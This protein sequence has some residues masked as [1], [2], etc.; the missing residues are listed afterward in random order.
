L[1]YTD[2][3]KCRKKVYPALE[4]CQV[5]SKALHPRFVAMPVKTKGSRAFAIQHRTAQENA[6]VFIYDKSVAQS[7]SKLRLRTYDEEERSANLYEAL[8]ASGVDSG[9]SLTTVENAF[10]RKPV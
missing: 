10:F 4:E 8:G 7:P 9:I 1:M 5:D 6:N 3:S 2:T